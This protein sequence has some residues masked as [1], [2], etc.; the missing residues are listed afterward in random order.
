MRHKLA[1]ISLSK[2]PNLHSLKSNSGSLVSHEFDGGIIMDNW[3]LTIALLISGAL[4]AGCNPRST[5]TA[6]PPH[7]QPTATPT[8]QINNLRAELFALQYRVSALESGE[9][10]VSTEEA[11]YGVAKTKFGP[12]TVSTRSATPYLDGFKVKLRIGNLTNANFNGAKLNVNWG[13]PLDEKNSKNLEEW[14][15]NQRLKVIDLTTNFPSGAFTDVEIVLT[16]AKAEDIKT[17]TVGI[18]LNQLSLRER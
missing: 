15:K 18:E 1:S 9:A 13:P 12:F 10:T 11:G 3:R 14:N 5:N 8:E 6:A 2:I 7:K 17:F 16:P 4:V